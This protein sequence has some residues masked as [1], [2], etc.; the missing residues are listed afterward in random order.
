M[1]KL[2][3]IVTIEH[4]ALKKLQCIHNGR[5][6]YENKRIYKFEMVVV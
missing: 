4:T 3:L 6:S 2:P 5:N 1:Q